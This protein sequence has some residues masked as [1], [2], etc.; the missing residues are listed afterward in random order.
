MS[1]R[2][3][4]RL[5]QPYFETKSLKNDPEVTLQMNPLVLPNYKYVGSLMTGVIQCYKITS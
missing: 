1:N 4:R 2:L 5:T 3:T